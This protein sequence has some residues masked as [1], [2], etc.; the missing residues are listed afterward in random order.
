MGE[1]NYYLK[2]RFETAEEA[3][4]AIPRLSELLGQGEAASEY[5]Q[6]SRGRIETSYTRPSAD[7]FW[8]GFRDHFPLVTKY[9]GKL[10]GKEDWSNGLAGQ[11]SA[12]I[13][14]RIKRHGDPAAF[15]QQDGDLLLL[16]LSGIWHCADFRRLHRFILKVL[17]A[18]DVGTVSEEEFECDDD[19]EPTM[20]D[21]EFF[22]AIDV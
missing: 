22:A 3:A 12:L 16:K 14:P 10:A 2:A 20:T 13:D 8:T 6:N 15:L 4:A 17:G 21:D 7:V 18:L 9:L 5:W 11:L 19:G 1:C